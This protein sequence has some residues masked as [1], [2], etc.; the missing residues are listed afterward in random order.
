MNA[1]NYQLVTTA[2]EFDTVIEQLV[3]ADR[4]AIDT[5]FHRERTYFPQVALVQ[6]TA[7]DEIWLIDPLEVD[8]APLA[9]ILDGDGLCL[10]H[11][12]SQDLEVLDLVCGTAPK[13]LLDT[14]IAAGFVG[15]SSGSL[16][17]LVNQF[18]GVHLPKGD[19]L[20]DWLRRPLT[21]DQLR[22]AASDVEHL[23]GLISTIE[24]KLEALD[25]ISW[26]E[27]ECRI[28]LDR[29]RGR[30]VP[31]DAILRLKEARSLSGE[32]FQVGASVAAW[33]ERRAAESNVPV[34]QVLSD[35]GV[36]AIAQRAPTTPKQLRSLRGVEQRHLKNG[37]DTEILTAVRAAR[38]MEIDVEPGNKNAQ[39]SRQLRPVVSLI[40]A[41]VSQL[42]RDNKLD[43][44][45][46]A[47][48][49][50]IEGLLK[51]DPQCRL[52]FGW[53]QELVGGPIDK[54]VSGTAAVAFNGDGRLLLEER[55]GR[56]LSLGNGDA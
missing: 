42:A 30:R 27:E 53:R 19:R 7:G 9:K 36:V 46:L 28:L 14:Q 1:P 48:R 10:I 33:R 29:P 47:T 45:I 25:R 23:H 24:E 17:S 20:T 39:L 3:D 50:D 35:L 4:Y 54:L 49:S 16:A 26:V 22:Y 11:A 37:A 15:V 43:P 6:L 34:R 44:A 56:E 32:A 55:S 21:D 5:E 8:L 13:R 52:N 2:D 31:E 12:G 40:T 38:T 41:W 18:L 51:K